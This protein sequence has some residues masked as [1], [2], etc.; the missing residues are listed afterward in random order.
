M[1]ARHRRWFQFSLRTM[2][3]VV[4]IIAAVS[5]I[6][7]AVPRPDA[8]LWGVAYA[9]AG[10]VC[11]RWV[12]RVDGLGKTIVGRAV[13]MLAAILILVYFMSMAMMGV[14]FGLGG[15]LVD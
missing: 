5:A 15:D 10:I 6:C 4:A 2:L 11:A 7:A 3:I 1:T 12:S 14:L 13:R 8:M 9:A